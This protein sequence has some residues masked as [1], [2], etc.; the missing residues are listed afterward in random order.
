MTK[1][2]F[3]M[4]EKIVKDDFE[5][6]T[7]EHDKKYLDYELIEEDES[8]KQVKFLKFSDNNFL[9]FSDFGVNHQ[10]DLK[11]INND[12]FNT[13]KNV[14]IEE[15]FYCHKEEF[16]PILRDKL[17][18]DKNSSLVVVF[19]KEIEDD[20][21]KLAKTIKKENDLYV[22]TNSDAKKDKRVFVTHQEL[23]DVF[24]IGKEFFI[25]KE[26]FIYEIKNID[27]KNE[28]KDFINSYF[29][30]KIRE[31][32]PN[33]DIS[34]LEELNYKIDSIRESIGKFT[35][36]TKKEFEDEIRK[37]NE[38]KNKLYGIDLKHSGKRSQ[39]RKQLDKWN[40]QNNDNELQ[41]YPIYLEN[42]EEIKELKNQVLQLEKEKEEFNKYEKE[43]NKINQEKSNLISE[44]N[45]EKVSI[46]EKELK[47][48]NRLKYE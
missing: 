35:Y 10:N 18:L 3:D 12:T 30:N 20:N 1:D 2:E 6:T 15:E 29:I 43:I 13:S 47:N 24:V 45:K 21:F 19:S 17:S 4:L 8:I 9:I 23:D 36:K 32:E 37:I 39:L 48:I 16:L 5:K 33:Y 11:F 40:E 42:R 27:E 31:I 34:K 14:L 26:N 22:F 41:K 7:K 46:F 28:I 44:V 38:N 25:R